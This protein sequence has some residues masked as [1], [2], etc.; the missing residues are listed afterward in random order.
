MDELKENDPLT[1]TSESLNS[2]TTTTST[3]LS[4]LMEYDRH[5]SLKIYE[6]NG[7]IIFDSLILIP[8]ILFGHYLIFIIIILFTFIF[9]SF[10]YPLLSLIIGI[11]TFIIKNMTRKKRPNTI[12]TTYLIN[13]NC[14][15]ID[16]FLDQTD[17]AFPSGDTAQSTL[18]ALYL[19]YFKN[20]TYY[21]MVIIIIVGFSR[22]YNG[23]HYISDVI[24]GAL[25]AVI[26]TIQGC[27]Y[28]IIT[29]SVEFD[30]IF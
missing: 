14:V 23:K 7:G 20:L 25:L 1:I 11:L 4:K 24:V 16:K 9:K 26:I 5:Y 30:N 19:S 13:Y 27:S 8:S 6:F 21:W 22:I 28:N 12:E 18:F 3:W 15:Y 2:S 29:D 17:Y 10:L